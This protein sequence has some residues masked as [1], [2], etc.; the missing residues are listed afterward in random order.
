ME[1]MG[2]KCIYIQLEHPK[3]GMVPSRVDY[4][5]LTII[6]P[7]YNEADNIGLM[8]K[9]LLGSYPGVKILVVDDCSTDGTPEVACGAMPQEG[10]KVIIRDPKDRGL[11]ASVMEGIM[12]V[13]TPY[14]VVMDADFQHPPRYVGSVASALYA[15]KDLVIGVREEKLSMLF[16]RQF[17]SGGAHL[18]ARSYLRIKGQPSSS[19]T[20]SGFFGGRTDLCQ[21]IITDHES[22]F[23]RKG[24]KVL[25]DLLKFMPDDAIIDEVVFKFDARQRGESKLNATII[26]SIL[27]Q[28]GIPGRIAATTTKFF[29]MTTPGRFV[30]A[31][32]L[33]VLSSLSVIMINGEAVE[34]IYSVLLVSLVFA[35]TLM[36]L[37][38][39]AVTRF[40]K[41]RGIDY[42]LILTGLA[43]LA[44]LL[45]SSMLQMVGREMPSILLGSALLGLL[46]AFGYDFIGCH[47]PKPAV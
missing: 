46:V 5:G 47:I 19:D 14:F 37:I 21:K 16:S 25:F 15:G 27:R 36:V 28:C 12:S 10:H 41:R 24:F 4:S 1:G 20:M 40:G 8:I 30:G 17:A 38:N 18:L 29:L 34:D 31:M 26:L 32:L 2:G 44:Y 45:S 13:K 33:G 22:K 39:E 43:F 23:E 9:A 35:I 6:L 42:G 7:T 3:D 11:T